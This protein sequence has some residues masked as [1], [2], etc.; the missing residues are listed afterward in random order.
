MLDGGAHFYDTY[1]TK[2]GEYMSVGAIEPQF[3][4]QLLKG[5]HLSLFQSYLKPGQTLIIY[6]WLGM[7]S[8]VQGLES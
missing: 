6:S 7:G 2:D 5:N 1:Q 4:A 3:Y 8:Q